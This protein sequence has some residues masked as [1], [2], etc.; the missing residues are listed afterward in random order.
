MSRFLYLTIILIVPFLDL[1]GR[2]NV[3][4]TGKNSLLY[5]GTEFLKQFNQAKGDPFFPTP[6]HM[7]S[8]HYQGQWYRDLEVH[9]DIEDD[10]VLIRDL[11][12]LLKLRLIREKLEGFE[13]DGHRFVKLKLLGG[14]GEYYE[15][16]YNGKIPLYLQWKKNAEL[17]NQEMVKY[18][19]KKILFVLVNGKVMTINSKFDLLTIIPEKEK[20]IKKIYRENRLNFKKDRVKASKIVMTEIGKKG[21]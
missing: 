14:S 3:D 7:G 19:L 4:T 16:L 21:W 1:K 10:I 6:D 9:Y 11:Q 12:G 18:E 5:S 2:S 15:E 8:V 13:I 17:D 20:E